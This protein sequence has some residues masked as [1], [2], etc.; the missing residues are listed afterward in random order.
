[1]AYSSIVRKPCKCG[2]G[3]PPSIGFGGYNSNCNPIRKQEI[4][5]KH[6]Q[7]QN[8]NTQVRK[9]SK[10]QDKDLVN[11]VVGQSGI[12]NLI[13]DL[14]FVVSRYVRMKGA[15][16]DGIVQCYTCTTKSHWTLMQASH[17]IPRQHLNTRWELANLRVGCPTCNC[18]KHGNLEV[19]AERLEKENTGIVEWLQEQ[20]REVSKFSQTELKELLFSFREKL[21]I[22]ETKFLQGKV[23]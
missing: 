17:F 11:K 3:K 19:Y 23:N 2:C 20:G 16:K 9:L 7:K 4:I 14:D 10:T 1:M 6:N 5:K 12:S 21:K 22:V 15:D 8:L 18:V 13:Q